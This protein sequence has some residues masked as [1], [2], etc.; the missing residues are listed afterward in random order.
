MSE[1]LQDL[2]DRRPVFLSFLQ[3][4]V[5]SQDVAEDI[6]QQGLMKAVERSRDL[7]AHENRTGWFTTVLHH[8]IIDHFRSATAT[9]RKLEGFF[10]EQNAV[11]SSSEDEFGSSICRCVVGLIN[12]LKAEDAKLI[13]QID[14]NG[15]ELSMVAAGLGITTG[16]LSVRLHRARRALKKILIRVCGVCSESKCLDCSCK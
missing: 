2:I 10:A 9:Q 12:R 16:H 11:S 13:Q 7:E 5:G 4:R 15:E 6:L 14:F 3:S 8:L 1:A